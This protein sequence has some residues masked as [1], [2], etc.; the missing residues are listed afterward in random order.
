LVKEEHPKVVVVEGLVGVEDDGKLHQA[1]RLLRLIQA[2][3]HHRRGMKER[4]VFW[5]LGQRFFEERERFFKLPGAN[6]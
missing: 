4:S 2:T 5:P 1:H 6:P 3:E